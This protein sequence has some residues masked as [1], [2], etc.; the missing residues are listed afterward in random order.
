MKGLGHQG[1]VGGRGQ[2]LIFRPVVDQ[3]SVTPLVIGMMVCL[4]LLTAGVTAVGSAFLA[5]QR[6]QRVCDGAVAAAVG[7]LDPRRNSTQGGSAAGPIQAAREYLRVR[8]PD[9]T[10]VVGLGNQSVDA[11]CSAEASITFGL[12][13]GAPTLRSTVTSSSRPINRENTAAPAQEPDVRT[14]GGAFLT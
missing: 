7:A 5:G 3:G 10:A 6:L 1:D 2:P 9:V 4:L 8:A 13:F 11:T 14:P 12:L